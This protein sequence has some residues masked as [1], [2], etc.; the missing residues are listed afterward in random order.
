M[1]PTEFIER[2]YLHDSC[3]QSAEF[4]ADNRTV[5][6]NIYFSFWMQKWYKTGQIEQGLIKAVFSGVSEYR[7]E[8]GDPTGMDVLIL[9]ARPTEKGIIISLLDDVACNCFE[10]TINAKSVEVF[11]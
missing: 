4:D 2:Y 1:R 3:I 8:G 6:L 9:E 11:V 5:A 7:C 10:M